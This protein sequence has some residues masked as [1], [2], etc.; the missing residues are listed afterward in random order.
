MVDGLGGVFIRGQED[1]Q[2]LGV[3]REFEYLAGQPEL[4]TGRVVEMEALLRIEALEIRAHV[5]RTLGVPDAALADIEAA[6]ALCATACADAATD[7]RLALR[8]KRMD[9]LSTLHRDDAALGEADAVWREVSALPEGFDGI[10]VWAGRQRASVLAMA[11][12]AD[13]G[14]RAFGLGA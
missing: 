13:E 11:G 10:R 14:A 12:R 8:L 4:V 9:L 6:L 1:D 3:R 5:R 2:L 7:E